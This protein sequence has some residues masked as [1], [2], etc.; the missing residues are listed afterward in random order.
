MKTNR[1][2]VQVERSAGQA[3]PAPVAGRRGT[4][5]PARPERGR[6]ILPH[7]ADTGL[8]AWAPDLPGLF[9]EAAAALGEIAAGSDVADVAATTAE[10]ADVRVAVEAPDLAGLAFAWLNELIGLADVHHAALAGTT[11]GRVDHASRGCAL[12]AVARYVDRAAPGVRLRHDVKSATF[13][14]LTVRR[15]GRTW[16]MV[17]YLDI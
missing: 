16:S 8:R 6:E 13:H 1:H 7:T 14:G 15:T 17:A 12:D 11:V 4:S 2:S 9:E 3:A 5:R 10:P